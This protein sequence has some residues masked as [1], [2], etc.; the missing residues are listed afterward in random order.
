MLQ[1]WERAIIHTPL[2]TQQIIHSGHIWEVGLPEEGGVGAT[3]ALVMRNKAFSLFSL[4]ISL[5]LEV[6]AS[7]YYLYNIIISIP[8]GNNCS[9]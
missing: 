2:D 7:I 5:L 9:F 1:I 3:P 6:F 4:H 8:N